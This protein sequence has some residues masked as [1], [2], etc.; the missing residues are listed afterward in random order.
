MPGGPWE[1]YPEGDQDQV[2]ITGLTPGMP[3]SGK[4]TPSTAGGF[5]WDS[6]WVNTSL[7]TGSFTVNQTAVFN[8]NMTLEV[9]V[10]SG[11]GEKYHMYEAS[12]ID[13]EVTF[14]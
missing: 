10:H 3:F 7:Y 1:F 13:T 11:S 5:E 4:V 9:I 8:R 12:S 2:K 14:T 6:C